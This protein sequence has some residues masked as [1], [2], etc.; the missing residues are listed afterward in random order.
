MYKLKPRSY[1]L[2]IRLKWSEESSFL[3]LAAV[4]WCGDT[5]MLAS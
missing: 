4:V 1:I 3:E 2:L 5:E